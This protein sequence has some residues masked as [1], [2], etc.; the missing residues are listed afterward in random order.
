MKS[1]LIKILEEEKIN[2]N[3]FENELFRK[4]EFKGSFRPI[5]IKP[6]DLSLL[7]FETDELF[8][9]NY[10]AKIEFSL[11]KGCYATMLLR[12]LMKT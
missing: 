1:A 3:I 11:Q 12:E 7:E 4:Y 5:L 9:N 2:P 10:K 8:P 6:T